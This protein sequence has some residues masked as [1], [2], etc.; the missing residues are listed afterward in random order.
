[1]KLFDSLLTDHFDEL[2]KFTSK[3][4]NGQTVRIIDLF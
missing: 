4:L 2:N 1:M 3:I